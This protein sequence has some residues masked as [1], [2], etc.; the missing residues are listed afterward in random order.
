MATA[1]WIGALV[2]AGRMNRD[3]FLGVF[4]LTIAIDLYSMR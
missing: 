4:M 3:F 2:V 1:I